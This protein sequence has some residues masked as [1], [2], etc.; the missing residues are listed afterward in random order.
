MA[1]LIINIKK[2]DIMKLTET[3]E[4][5]CGA[6]LVVTFMFALVFIGAIIG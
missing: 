4:I 6:T 2:N 3:L 5:V 1:I